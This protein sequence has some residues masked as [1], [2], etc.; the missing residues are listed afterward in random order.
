MARTTAEMTNTP[1][2][3]EYTTTIASPELGKGVYPE[4][5][6]DTAAPTGLLVVAC[7]GKIWYEWA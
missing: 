2:T 7:G 6:W 1:A 4:E 3:N 5:E